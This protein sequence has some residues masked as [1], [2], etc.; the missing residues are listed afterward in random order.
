MGFG[1]GFAGTLY[2][3]VCTTRVGIGGML[4]GAL[5]AVAGEP[6]RACDVDEPEA[7]GGGGGFCLSLTGEPVLARFEVAPSTSLS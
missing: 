4:A 2:S 3:G 7:I 1:E 6:V 5:L